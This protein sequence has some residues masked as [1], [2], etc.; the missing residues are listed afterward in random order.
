MVRKISYLIYTIL[1]WINSIIQIIFKKN[2]LLWFY[3]FIQNDSHKLKKIK[4]KNISFFCP[5]HLILFRIKTF[6]TKEPETINWIEKFKNKK[7]KKIVF[8]DIGANIGIFSIYSSIIHKRKIEITSFEPSASNLRVLLR[9]I[10]VNNLGYNICV[11]QLP[12]GNENNKYVKFFESSFNEGSAFHNLD[13]SNGKNKITKNENSCSI[14]STNLDSLTIDKNF[15]YPNYIKIDVDGNEKSIL[16][17]A[18]KIFNNSSLKSILI[19]LDENDKDFSKIKSF[20]KKYKF[21]MVSSHSPPIFMSNKTN[22]K[23]FIFE[24]Y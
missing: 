10:S 13:F 18:K 6:F 16:E 11:N 20:F 3:T 9:N 5:N 19:E 4:N 7:N 1:K 24:R 8:W 14:Y 23:N 21:K 15:K 12:I 22:V 2:F 17:G